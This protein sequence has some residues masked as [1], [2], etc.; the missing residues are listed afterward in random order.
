MLQ[1]IKEEFESVCPSGAIPDDDVIDSLYTYLRDA[2]NALSEYVPLSIIE[3]CEPVCYITYSGE[4]TPDGKSC[5]AIRKYMIARAYFE[6]IPHLDLVL[7]S[8]GFGIVSNNNV[9]PASKERVESLR[10]QMSLLYQRYL[11]D[12]ILSLREN[13]EFLEYFLMNFGK[14]LFWNS[15]TLSAFGISRRSFN[16]LLEKTPEITQGEEYVK[17]LISPAQF[18]AL[19][20][21]E[22][23]GSADFIQRRAAE[24][25][26]FAAVFSLKPFRD[27]SVQ[28]ALLSFLD[29]NIER[30]SPYRNSTAFIAN[31][32]GRYENGEE[33]PC[34]FF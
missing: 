34:Y 7:T 30:F 2:K 8:T 21:A 18:D 11:E 29:E 10:D 16:V 20:R 9:A 26:R 22:I 1:Y 28:T 24:L 15:S 4:I 33:D 3:D 17:E 6:A 32:R 23:S 19:V 25:C 12:V 13:E 27:L 5:V 14:S 31:H